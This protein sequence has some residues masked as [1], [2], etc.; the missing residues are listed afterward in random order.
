MFIG[1]ISY[2]LADLIH[3]AVILSIST[4]NGTPVFNWSY[5]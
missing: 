1:M 5:M 3:T 2:C 4:N